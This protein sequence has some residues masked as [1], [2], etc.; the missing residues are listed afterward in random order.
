MKGFYIPQSGSLIQHTVLTL[1]TEHAFAKATK[2]IPELSLSVPKIG[3]PPFS[4]ESVLI[5]RIKFASMEENI[6]RSVEKRYYSGNATVG[7][8]DS[9]S[10]LILVFSALL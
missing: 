2:S 1:C 10:L 6:K 3:T 7:L 8:V 9:E 5:R 4:T